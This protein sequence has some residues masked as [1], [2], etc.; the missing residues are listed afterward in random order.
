MNYSDG[1]VEAGS[2]KQPYQHTYNLWENSAYYDIN[3]L[4]ARNLVVKESVE[5]CSSSEEDVKVERDAKNRRI[6][7]KESLY[8]EPPSDEDEQSVEPENNLQPEASDW[9]SQYWKKAGRDTNI[10]SPN[11][12]NKQQPKSNKIHK[13]LNKALSQPLK[14]DKAASMMAKMGWQGGAL[15]R[16]G[17]GIVE[18]I[19]PN[20]EYATRATTGFGQPELKLKP[21]QKPIAKNKPMQKHMKKKLRKSNFKINVLLHILDF[22][23]ND[24]EI[25]VMFASNLASFERKKIHDIV[26][27]VVNAETIV[28]MAADSI[29]EMDI[30]QDIIKY[31]NYILRTESEGVMPNRS[32]CIYKEAPEHMYLVTHKDLRYEP[33][34]PE[35]TDVHMDTETNDDATED[36]K[37]TVQNETKEIENETNEN[38]SDFDEA[39]KDMDFLLDDDE[40]NEITAKKENTIESDNDT[41]DIK[42]EENRVE[43]RL[44]KTYYITKKGLVKYRTKKVP[45]DEKPVNNANRKSKFCKVSM[46]ALAKEKNPFLKSILSAQKP[47]NEPLTKADLKNQILEYFTEFAKEDLYKEFKFLGPFEGIEV[48]AINEF[49]NN[50]W[51]CIN[52]GDYLNDDILCVMKDAKCGFAIMEE[53]NGSALIYKTKRQE[54][55][56]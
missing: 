47:N 8:K 56:T 39:E 54:S 43:T 44:V 25:E 51:M 22:V 32:L 30:F 20:T 2:S 37:K 49:I 1:F 9:T 28:A 14:I 3:D 4:S 31:N 41:V 11:V 48:E 46:N 36:N 29:A 6:I 26:E 55:D 5:P 15:G 45:V 13:K 42:E 18:P 23:K 38:S 24:Y 35:Q 10:T 21:R 16:T 17:T 7:S 50:L 27:E 12:Q 52:D 53:A 34:E 19:A 33:E 40:T